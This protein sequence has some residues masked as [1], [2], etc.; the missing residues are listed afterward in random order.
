VVLKAGMHLA[1]PCRQRPR[2]IGAGRKQAPTLP[3]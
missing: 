2:G 1:S 3:R